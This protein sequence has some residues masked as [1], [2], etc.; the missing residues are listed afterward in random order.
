MNIL[1]EI[2]GFTLLELLIA[3]A[4]SAVILLGSYSMF[5]GVLAAAGHLNRSGDKFTEVQAFERLI[6]RD[7]R[8][9]LKYGQA[10]NETINTEDLFFSMV[11]Q[12]SITFNKSIPVSIT[13]YLEE[14]AIYR[15]EKN[16]SMNYLMRMP[17][18]S[19]VAS[20]KAEGYDGR[21]YGDEI[22]EKTAIFR[23]SFTMDNASYSFT[24]ARLLGNIGE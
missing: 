8:M 10:D 12:N 1:K 3:L 4:I 17:L 2:K 19:N 16:T 5:D 24:A 15:E 9:M 18:L 11:S 14:G 23:F 13:Y 20:A 21:D 6:L 7:V 22:S